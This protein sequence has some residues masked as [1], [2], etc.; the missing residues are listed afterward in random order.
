MAESTQGALDLINTP[1]SSAGDTTTYAQAGKGSLGN[2]GTLAYDP[3]QS[4]K[5]LQQM[6]DFQAT[7]NPKSHEMFDDDKLQKAIAYGKTYLGGNGLAELRAIQ[8]NRQQQ[9]LNSFNM[10]MQIEEFKAAQQQQALFNAN[11]TNFFQNMNKGFTGEGNVGPGGMTSAHFNQMPIETQMAL[12]NARNQEEWNKVFNPYQETIVK[13]QQQ[14]INNP[15]TYKQ[16]DHYDPRNGGS[17]EK[18]SPQNLRKG[19]YHGGPNDPTA[20]NPQPAANQIPRDPNYIPPTQN[21]IVGSSKN[22]DQ[23]KSPDVLNAIQSGV[24][25]QESG[26]GANAK[27]SVQG[28]VGN[29]QVT[30]DT[31]KTFQNIG[32]IPKD[33][34]INDPK[35]NLEGGKSIL[36]YYYK[37]YNGDIDKTVASYFGGEGAVNPDGSIN[38]KR[39]DANN[40][41][42][43]QYIQGVRQKS[44]LPTANQ[45]P[46]IDQNQNQPSPGFTGQNVQVASADNYTPYSQFQISQEASKAGLTKEKE[47]TSEDVAKRQNAMLSGYQ[48]S[49][50]DIANIDA[51][52]QLAIT[53][54]KAFGVLQNPTVL[55]AI[56][57]MVKSGVQDGTVGSHH[58]AAIE[59]AIRDLTPDMSEA[60][61]TAAQEAAQKL[62]RLELNAAKTFLKGQGSVS[63]NERALITKL[64]GSLSNSPAALHNIMEWNKIHVNESRDFGKAFDAWENTHPN[65]SYRQFEKSNEYRSIR[66]KYNNQYDDLAA[67]AGKYPGASGKSNL[68]PPKPPPGYDPNWRSKIKGFF[69]GNQ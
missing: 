25:G 63:D 30:P 42:I 57:Q 65:Q 59:D 6:Q 29:M 26:S 1:S 22:T 54:P 68:G 46:N 40:V 20:V 50:E 13:G 35:Q 10:Q 31:W 19:D 24:F 64:T 39:H 37:K 51:I 61:L 15:D 3:A 47:L 32:V 2:L 58:I 9:E 52:N 27:P 55:S 69:G 4:S 17:I 11:K 60:D 41:S 62:S 53:H 45:N 23:A 21:A 8:N 33:A 67:K 18:V 43:D 48:T 16:V 56:G 5:V 66:D 28:A 14:W 7:R 36:S 38:L 34:D 12:M 49:G 44:G